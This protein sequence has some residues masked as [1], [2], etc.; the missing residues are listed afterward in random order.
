M[1]PL[2]LTS[3]QLETLDIMHFHSD[4]QNSDSLICL[5]NHYSGLELHQSIRTTSCIH[6]AHGGFV[7]LQLSTKNA[8][9]LLRWSP[10][11]LE[12]RQRRVALFQSNIST[13]QL[14]VLFVFV[15][16]PGVLHADCIFAQRRRE[17]R[18]HQEDRCD[19]G[20]ARSTP[21]EVKS[22]VISILF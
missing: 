1:F 8:E 22:A 19:C 12:Y 6:P 14:L 13:D 18:I 17:N 20:I 4:F 10:V 15:M 5:I 7:C 21:S 16:M 11:F 2:S 9:E 3:L